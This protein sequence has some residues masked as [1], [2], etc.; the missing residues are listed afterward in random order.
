[1]LRSIEYIVLLLVCNTHL[2]IKHSPKK[3]GDFTLSKL[4]C[5]GKRVGYI[6][7]IGKQTRRG[8]T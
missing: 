2:K 7:E 6:K 4:I 1:M 3:I 5:L 8:F